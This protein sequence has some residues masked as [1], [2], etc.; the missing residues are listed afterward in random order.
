MEWDDAKSEENR[1]I[2]GFGF[3]IAY[4]FDWANAV[5]RQADRRDYGE[6]R[7]IAFGWARQRR[8]AIVYTNRPSGLRIISVRC[9]HDKEA[10]KYGI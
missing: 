1:L 3:E 7:Y 2:R 10:R 5:F 6:R 9:M 8:L 4:E